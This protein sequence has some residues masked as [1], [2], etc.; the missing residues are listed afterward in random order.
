LIVN[1]KNMFF[2][3]ASALPPPGCPPSSGTAAGYQN[4]R[5]AISKATFFPMPGSHRENYVTCFSVPDLA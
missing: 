2:T 5:F 3:A 1:N 4:G